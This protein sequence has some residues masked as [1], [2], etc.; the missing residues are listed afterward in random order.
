LDKDAVGRAQA[1]GAWKIEVDID[2]GM[3]RDLELGLGG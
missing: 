1:T 2:I 3:K